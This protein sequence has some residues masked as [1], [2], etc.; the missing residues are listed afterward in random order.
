M[1]TAK[2]EDPLEFLV[3]ARVLLPCH[4]SSINSPK[5]LDASSASCVLLTAQIH[6]VKRSLDQENILWSL[7]NVT[8]HRLQLFNA[9]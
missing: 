4:N 3:E 9:I 7:T 1:S 6:K 2:R 8:L 5:Q